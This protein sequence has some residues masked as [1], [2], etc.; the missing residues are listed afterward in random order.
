MTDKIFKGYVCQTGLDED[1]G[2]MESDTHVFG[3]IERLKNEKRCWPKC[4]IYEVEIKI[5]KI[6]EPQNYDAIIDDD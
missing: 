3:N 5:I 6:V 1:V 4:G 2:S